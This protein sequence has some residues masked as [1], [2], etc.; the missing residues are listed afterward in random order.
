MIG[1]CDSRSLGAPTFV[2]MGSQR[3]LSS[4]AVTHISVLAGATNQALSLFLNNLPW[5]SVQ[6]T[7]DIHAIHE[8]LLSYQFPWFLPP[9]CWSFLSLW[10]IRNCLYLRVLTKL[11]GARCA[12]CFSPLIPQLL[13]AKG[14]SRRWRK[15]LARDSH[16]WWNV[17]WLCSPLF[18]VVSHAP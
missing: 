8:Q 7:A 2:S 18:L 11:L 16:Q 9:H 4:S 13:R 3:L 10:T 17:L 12:S 1:V 5:A 15:C 6:Q 14:N